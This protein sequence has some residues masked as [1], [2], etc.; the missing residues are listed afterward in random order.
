MVISTSV[1]CMEA[2]FH[3]LVVLKLN[4]P[5][6]HKYWKQCF[7]KGWRQIVSHLWRFAFDKHMDGGDL[8]TYFRLQFWKLRERLG[9]RD[10]FERL[11]AFCLTVLTEEAG[12][13]ELVKV[14]IMKSWIQY[15]SL[16][17]KPSSS[18]KRDLGPYK[19]LCRGVKLMCREMKLPIAHFPAS[20]MKR[21]RW[22]RLAM[23]TLAELESS[24]PKSKRW[25]SCPWGTQLCSKPL[26]WRWEKPSSDFQS[27]M[28]L[29]SFKMNAN[30]K[31][32]INV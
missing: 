12:G 26:G 29:D 7:R 18:V 22:M 8:F 16:T 21:S 5:P 17:T 2:P 28:H 11:K 10:G 4:V 27:S 9:S 30:K 23:M 20:R 13:M 14:G 15:G 19:V 3:S 31:I 25:W 24:W 32:F 1:Y 6:S